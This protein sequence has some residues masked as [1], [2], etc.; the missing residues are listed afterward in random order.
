MFRQLVID[1][2]PFE[3]VRWIKKRKQK[4]KR[5]EKKILFTLV[6]TFSL[7]AARRETPRLR[8][9]Q[10]S[11]FLIAFSIQK[12]TTTMVGTLTQMFPTSFSHSSFAFG[13][14]RFFSIR[15]KRSSK[16]CDHSPPLST[17][18]PH[19]SKC[20]NPYQLGL[21]VSCCCEVTLACII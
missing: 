19:I 9:R 14:K 3:T 18:D 2:Y 4:R 12:L 1:L 8:K 6:F 21:V 20:L 10:F 17:L 7:M 11:A 15:S 13:A 5:R 16:K